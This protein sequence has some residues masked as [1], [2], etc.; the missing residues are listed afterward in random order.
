MKQSTASCLG[1]LAA[2]VLSAHAAFAQTPPGW[3]RE[4]VEWRVVPGWQIRGLAYPQGTAPPLG[5]RQGPRAAHRQAL[6]AEKAK[7][8]PVRPAFAQATRGGRQTASSVLVIDSPPVDGFVPWV[9]MAVTGQH[10][11]LYEPDAVFTT[12]AGSPIV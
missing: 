11:S 12:S 6:P 7:Q 2:T 4:G 9:P 10:G 5:K 8:R 1:V 3:V